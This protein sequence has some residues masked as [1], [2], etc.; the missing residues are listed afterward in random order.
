MAGFKHR[1]LIL[2][3]S[4]RRGHNALHTLKRLLE[5]ELCTGFGIYSL[6]LIDYLEVLEYHEALGMAIV[7]CNLEVYK[8]LCYTIVTLCKVNKMEIRIEIVAVSGI[9]RRAKRRFLDLT[10]R[11]GTG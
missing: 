2:E 11:S 8:Y 5:R 1:Y 6:S 10:A 3:I 4:P 7:R 9:L